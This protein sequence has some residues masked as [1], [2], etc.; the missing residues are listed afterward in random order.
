M[1]DKKKR[2]GTET[3]AAKMICG[4][5]GAA[6]TARFSLSFRRSAAQ[7]CVGESQTGIAPRGSTCRGEIVGA[8]DGSDAFL[9]KL[10]PA[11]FLERDPSTLCHGSFCSFA[12]PK[13][14][15]MRPTA[16]L[17]DR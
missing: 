1:T 11:I 2:A 15:L 6:K 9:C 4:K 5:E 10:P 7:E 16:I 13:P 3:F 12:M 17:Q 14:P 8:R